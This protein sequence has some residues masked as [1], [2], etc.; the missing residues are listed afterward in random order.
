MRLMGG[1]RIETV[2]QWTPDIILYSD[3]D[4]THSGLECDSIEDARS[5]ADALELAGHARMGIY[6][7]VSE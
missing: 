5:K 6:R 7:K 4:S 2:G 3:L 1:R